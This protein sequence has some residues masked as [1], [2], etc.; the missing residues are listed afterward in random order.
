M[1]VATAIK[2]LCDLPAKCLSYT[3][4]LSLVD[5]TTASYPELGRFGEAGTTI[6]LLKDCSLLPTLISKMSKLEFLECIH[7]DFM[8]LKDPEAFEQ[9]FSSLASLTRLDCLGVMIQGTRFLSMLS[10]VPQLKTI[11]IRTEILDINSGKPSPTLVRPTPGFYIPAAAL[12]MP[13]M[14]PRVTD[15]RWLTAIKAPPASLALDHLIVHMIGES[16]E[17]LVDLLSHP[18]ISPFKSVR[19]ITLCVSAP[20]DGSFSKR[21]NSLLERTVSSLEHLRLEEADIGRAHPSMFTC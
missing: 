15:S 1:N 21:V 20:F 13:G 8:G 19:F 5:S 17:C 14:P 9:A 4:K 7:L 11:D 16:N 12:S 2:N 10:K 18:P 3:T 6:P